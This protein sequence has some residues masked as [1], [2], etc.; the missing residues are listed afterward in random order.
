MKRSPPG[1]FFILPYFKKFFMTTIPEIPDE[2]HEMYEHFR[3][4]ADPGQELL[5]IDKFLLH[6]IANATR[7]RIQAALEG[8]TILVNGKTS[9]SSYK[10]KPGDD[11]SIIFAYPKKEIELIPQDLPITII[12]EDDDIIIVNKE[13]GMVVH[14]GVGNFTGTL[15]N[16]LVYHCNQLPKKERSA[17]DPFNELRPGLVHRI[18][19]NTSGLLVIAKN[20]LAMNKLAKAFF[21][22]TVERKYVAVVWGDLKEDSGTV[23]AHI[24]RDLR[25]R[26]KMAAFPEGNQGRHATTHFTVLERLKNVSVIECVLETGRTHQIRVHMQYLGHPVFNDATYGGDRI[27][28]G[29]VNTKYRQFVE[30][31]FALIP[32][33]A[34]HA[35]TLGFIHPTTGKK[36]HFEAEPPTGMQALIDKWRRH[37]EL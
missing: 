28:R 11:V 34:L 32:G 15:M 25:D 4:V 16:A 23:I 8:G 14:P 26:K 33:Q 2:D 12:Y 19:K 29:Q 13:A 10:I 20:D 22:K 21:E 17:K 5:R 36:V 31:A 24:G 9:K 27:L 1:S 35:K 37:F 6:K 18:D 3:F 30:N 7:T